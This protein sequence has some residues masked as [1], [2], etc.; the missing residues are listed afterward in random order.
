MHIRLVEGFVHDERRCC[1]A[2]LLHAS[3]WGLAGVLEI[4]DAAGMCE[5]KGAQFGDDS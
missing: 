4:T 2:S 1:R 5:T 3:L